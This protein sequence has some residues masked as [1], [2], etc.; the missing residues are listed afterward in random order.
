[1][2]LFAVLCINL[3]HYVA[4]VK[5]GTTGN[6]SWVFFDSMADRIGLYFLLSHNSISENTEYIYGIAVG[7]GS[8]RG[9]CCSRNLG[10]PKNNAIINTQRSRNIK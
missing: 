3:S 5:C 9:P 6:S 8:P 2:E 7:R 10:C 1:M 4:F